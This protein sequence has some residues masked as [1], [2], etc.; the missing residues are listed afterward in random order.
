MG[1]DVG[2]LL[3]EDNLQPNFMPYPLTLKCL[4]TSKVRNCEWNLKAKRFALVSSIV[5]LK[6]FFNIYPIKFRQKSG[7]ALKLAFQEESERVIGFGDILGRFL[8][9][10]APTNR[11]QLYSLCGRASDQQI[12]KQLCPYIG[13]TDQRQLKP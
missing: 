5:H 13:P 9:N 7:F 4:A 10:G 8:R 6:L 11:T 3:K 12:T 2:K 1:K